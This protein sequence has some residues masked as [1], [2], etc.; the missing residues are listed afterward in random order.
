MHESEPEDDTN[1]KVTQL[2]KSPSKLEPSN[3][4]RVGG[5]GSLQGVLT[6]KFFF[7]K[8]CLNHKILTRKMFSIRQ[9]K[10]PL[11]NT[12]DLVTFGTV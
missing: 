4:V 2:P 3:Q 8:K 12:L 1:E 5:D 10:L 6:K 11:L 9:S 7:S